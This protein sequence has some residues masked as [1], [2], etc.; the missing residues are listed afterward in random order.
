MCSI[1]GGAPLLEAG[2]SERGFL[3]SRHSFPMWPQAPDLTATPT[4]L[5]KAKC[6]GSS[7]S[8]FFL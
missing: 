7:P 1:L 4:F 8:G 3:K 6:S 5:L 2:D